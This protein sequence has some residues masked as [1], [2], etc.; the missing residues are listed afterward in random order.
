[1]AEVPIQ[2][3]ANEHAY[4]ILNLNLRRSSSPGLGQK[5]RKVHS[6]I[7]AII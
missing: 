1:M 2:W 4:K 7:P 5:V 3:L 6:S